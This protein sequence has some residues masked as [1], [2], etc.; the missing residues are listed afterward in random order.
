MIKKNSFSIV[1]FLIAFV[2][3][4][5]LVTS[6]K[7]ADAVTVDN[8][9][10]I[11][12]Q[13]PITSYDFARFNGPA[14]KQYERMQSDASQGVFTASDTK[15]MSATKD[16]INALV[17]NV[18]LKQ[19]EEKA[20]IYI[21]KKQLSRYIKSVAH[22][23]NFTENQFFNFLKKRGISKARYIKE[24]EDRFARI[25]LLRKVYSNKMIVTKK[26]ILDYYKQNIEEFRG[27]PMVNLKLIFL[28]VPHNANKLLR[29]KIYDKMLKIRESAIKGNDSFS[30]LAKKYSED[31]SEKNGG[32]MGYIYK[33]KLSPAFS[34]AAFKLKVGQI[35]SI[36][37]SPFGYTLLKSV[38]RKMGAFKAFKQVKPE[39]FSILEKNRVDKYLAK[40]LKKA[41]KDA[42]IKMKIPV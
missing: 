30:S 37:K 35:S 22:A 38:G 24:I 42:Y 11:V 20:A 40:F 32:R 41:R 31:P 29:K 18:L 2:M 34:D 26:E 14:F 9:I 7:Y 4:L 23:N 16:V 27:T 28:S 8:I 33:N 21:S 17:D 19:A 39:I 6:V 1:I 10:A 13:T 5:T 15:I 12:N 36:L 3:G 25:N